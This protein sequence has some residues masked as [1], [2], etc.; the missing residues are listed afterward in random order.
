MGLSKEDFVEVCKWEGG[1]FEEKGVD[2][3]LGLGSVS[4]FVGCVVMF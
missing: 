3:L 4:G 2:W 1:D